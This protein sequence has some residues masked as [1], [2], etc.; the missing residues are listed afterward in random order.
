MAD[1]AQFE[2]GTTVTCTDGPCGTVKRVIIDPAGLTVSHLVIGPRHRRGHGRLV[3]LDLV[4][5]AGED[6]RLSCTMAQFEQL[7]AAE[8]LDLVE[9]PNSDYGGGFASADS[10]QGYS[11]LGVGSVSRTGT[12][13]GLGHRSRTVTEDVVPLGE[14]EV[15]R[16][17][18]VHALDGEI[19][20][21][22]GFVVGPDGQ[23]L[24]HVLLQEGHP[25]GRKEV[26]IPLSAVT[27]ADD[28]IRLSI[29]KEQVAA[30]PPL[31]D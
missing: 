31:T 30:L 23:H 12:G 24:T 21:V 14:T 7:D 22:A 10:V 27:R 6:I 1:A 3:P 9:G 4:A 29:T 8:E 15:G 20:R 2:I 11:G 16:G 13:G 19:G 28:G 25:W 5:A 17:E 26:A 18:P